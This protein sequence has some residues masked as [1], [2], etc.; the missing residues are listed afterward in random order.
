MLVH[1]WDLGVFIFLYLAN[2][3]N[4]TICRKNAVLAS[5]MEIS[6]FNHLWAYLYSAIA[7]YII[8]TLHKM[9]V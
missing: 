8:G 5:A 4:I 9:T 2:F 3:F 7:S 6:C 1:G